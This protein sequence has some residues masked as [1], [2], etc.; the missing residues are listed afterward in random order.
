LISFLK[1]E[2][3]GLDFLLRLK[4]RVHLEVYS[5]GPPPL[6]GEG[7]K[8]LFLSEAPKT[9][10]ESK[11]SHP[12]GKVDR[13]IKIPS[14][15]K[16][17]SRFLF[18]YK[19]IFPS[20]WLDAL[21]ELYQDHTIAIA[22]KEF[23]Y[24]FLSGRTASYRQVL[25]FINRSGNVLRS[26]G[27]GKGDR[28]VLVPSNRVELAWLNFAC[29]KIGAIPVPVNFMFK[30]PEIRYIVDNS[31]AR[32]LIT[33]QD[34]FETS[35]KDRGE[36]P[37]IK[38]L[39]TLDQK[40]QPG[41]Q[42]LIEL[43]SEAS[44]ELVAETQ[45]RP[46]DVVQIFYTSGTT[47]LPKG[48]MIRWL[49]IAAFIRFMLSISALYP[50]S[51]TDAIM[52][53]SMP[54]AHIMGMWICVIQF[55]MAV[56]WYFL[57][58]FDPE[59]CLKLMEQER[60]TTF[61]GVPTMYT[62]LFNADIED[63]CLENMKLW[64]SA[65]D[66]MPYEFIKRIQNLGTGG[67]LSPLFVELY[68]QV[69]TSGMGTV[70]V[71]PPWRDPAA[72]GIG[73]P[74]PWVKLRV[75][76][77]SGIPVKRGGVGELEMKGSNV[78]KGYWKND[79]AT[80]QAFDEGWFRTGDLARRGR[81]GL[82]YFV[83]RKSDRIKCGGYSVFSAE[84]EEEMRAFA[85]IEDVAVIGIPDSVKGEVPIA[86]VTL[87]QGQSAHPREIMDWARQNIAHYKCPRRIEVLD[88][89]PYGS[90]QKMLKKELRRRFADITRSQ[91]ENS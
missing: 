5:S 48:A 40:P 86:C 41:C 72:G 37:Y 63:Y 91:P 82:F 30:V 20:N 1:N 17:I 76:D 38:H 59:K 55:A 61:I 79:E 25:E 22:E 27:V 2:L 57:N 73:L 53:S 43:I 29:W 87:K 52:V 78:L 14:R 49:G 15:G 69:E 77:E 13:V 67:L 60:A 31:G 16:R 68:G 75:V 44:P 33:D 10:S 50:R 58:R 71:I 23:D 7:S 34:V 83:D 9:M 42:S 19:Q 62:M 35:I 46:S 8:G 65:A 11:A 70:R 90:T 85:K 6:G 66:K 39:L 24:P 45:A 84:V 47:G 28:V 21:A 89:M 18:N 51:T 64:G 32:V 74:L 88:K 26:L 12:E 56:P 80:K 36:I 54:L 81:L 3:T 4:N